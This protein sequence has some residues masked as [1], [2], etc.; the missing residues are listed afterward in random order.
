MEIIENTISLC[1]H[2]LFIGMFYQLLFQLFDWS[3]W[4]KNSHDNS[5]RLRLF[6]LLL[7]IALGYLVSNFMLAVLNFSRLLMWQG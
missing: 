3:R 2:L 4:I 5:W 1:S 7:S 6:L